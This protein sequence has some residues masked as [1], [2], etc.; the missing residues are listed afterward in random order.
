MMWIWLRSTCVPLYESFLIA[1]GLEEFTRM[2]GRLPFLHMS[3][4]LLTPKRF[5]E[6]LN[7]EIEE[8][9]VHYGEGRRNP[10]TLACIYAR[11]EER[12]SGAS[13]LGV[14]IGETSMLISI[15][16]MHPAFK[17]IFSHLPNT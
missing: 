10:A 13:L 12:L 8:T 15:L 4:E 9:I 3:K 16:A 17:G 2:F 6:I 1:R 5:A 7:E 14:P 11:T